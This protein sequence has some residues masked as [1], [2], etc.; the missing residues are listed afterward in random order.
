MKRLLISFG[1]LCAAAYGQRPS[2]GGGSSGGS[3]STLALLSQSGT[4]AAIPATCTA[5]QLYFAT[6][7]TPGQNIYECASANSWTQQLNS[8]SGGASTALD[9]LASV[10]VNTSLLAQTGV[11]IGSTTKPFRELFIWGTGTFGSTY[12]KFTGVP[13]GTRTQ[14]LQDVTDTFVYRA[15]TDTLTNKTLTTPTIASFTNATHNHTNAAGGGQLNPT[16]ALTTTG[17]PSSSTFLRGD[18]S[19]ATPS[20][21]GTVTVVGAGNLTS[22]ALVTGGGS[23]ALQTPAASATMDSSGN[24]STP[25]GITT[26]AGG[27]V[28]GFNQFGQGTATSPAANSV[29]IQAPTS[30]TTAYSMSLPGAAGTGFVLNTDSSNVDTLSF[31][32]FTGTGNV[33]RATSPTFVTPVLGTPAS[34]VMT[35]MTGLP[36]AATPLTTRGDILVVNSTPALARLAKGTQYQTLQGGASDTLFDAVHLDQATATTGTLPVGSGGTGITALG[37]GVAA[38]LGTAVSGSGAI[39]LAT[40]SACASGSGTTGTSVTNTTPVTAA[41]NTTSEQFLMELGLGA[42]YLNSSGQP[43]VISG[44][45]LYTTPVAQTPTITITARL[46]TVSGCGSGTNRVLATI[47]TTATIASVTNNPVNINLMAINHATGATGTLEVYGPL[48]V[49][50]GALTTTADS[51]FNDVN[52]AVT[53]TIDLTAALFVDFTATFSTNAAGPNSITQRAGGIM[54][55]AATAAPVTSV[56][57]QTGAVGNLSGDVTTS[58]SLATTIAANAVSSGKMAVVNTRQVCDIPVGDTSGSAISNAQLGPQSRVCYIPYAATIV[59]MDVNADAGTPNVIIGV[60]HAGSISNIVSGALATAASGGI[61]CSKTT[62][63]TGINGATTC[64]N[65]LQNTSIAAGDYLEL[66]S[67]TAGGTAK[68]FVAHVIY[69]IN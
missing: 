10:S 49:D 21:T 26:G 16:T 22:T 51:I 23:Q 42:G 17:T 34:G 29:L 53:G 68:F 8:G 62:A 39:C 52:T 58:G 14:T 43:F 4:L 15:T 9:N 41:T 30:V 12:I 20:G 69:T 54:P 48:S 7:A 32:G 59:E 31:V 33:A 11:D 46:C 5:G 2:S 40:A 60:N 57:G 56:F 67:G 3:G 44:K 65:T 25:G 24:I 38:A 50:L 61:A 19:W 6:N 18:N 37:T 47:V 55:Y 66:V 45:F 64:T 27:T 35:N 36:L 28:A 1:L 63:V 13:T